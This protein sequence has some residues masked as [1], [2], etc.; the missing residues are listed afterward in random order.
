MCVWGGGGGDKGG[1]GVRGGGGGYCRDKKRGVGSQELM[2]TISG[3]VSA[4]T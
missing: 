4:I 2:T 1:E 3:E